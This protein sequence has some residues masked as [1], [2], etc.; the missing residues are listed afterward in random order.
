MWQM[1]RQTSAPVLLMA[2]LL[3]AG[4]G[5]SIYKAATSFSVQVDSPVYDRSP[6][7]AV[8]APE[9]ETVIPQNDPIAV[10]SDQGGFRLPDDALFRIS[11][12]SLRIAESLEEGS[13]SSKI[14][15]SEGLDSSS[16]K[17]DYL[18]NLYNQTFQNEEGDQ[19]IKIIIKNDLS[20]RE[21]AQS[22]IAFSLLPD[23]GSNLVLL[24]L[25]LGWEPIEGEWNLVAISDAGL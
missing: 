10:R 24:S 14:L 4:V 22:E 7:D 15:Q 13:L 9:I 20:S 25:N 11:T 1:I 18:Q 8:V 3:L 16:S 23:D 19:S 6:S 17:A 21:F 12:G 2:A 5:Y